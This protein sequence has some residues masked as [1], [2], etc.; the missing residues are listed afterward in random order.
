MTLSLK[1]KM[2]FSMSLLAA[3]CTV[4]AEVV[5][6]AAL[7]QS[8]D[9]SIKQQLQATATNLVS[10]GISNYSDLE[11]VENLDFFIE[12]TLQLEKINQV[13]Q[14]FNRKGKLMFGSPPAANPEFAK[15]FSPQDSPFFSMRELGGKKYKIL[16]TPYKS[17]TGKEYFLQ[18]AMAYPQF[19]EIVRGTLHWAFLLFLVLLMMAF[20]ISHFLVK[21][22]LSP[23]RSIAVYLN[24][25]DP[26]TTRQWAPLIIPKS[27]EYLGDIV[28]GINQLT[29][30]IKSS[31]Y[32]MSRI[33]RYLAHELRNPL[34]ILSGEAQT[35]LKDPK[36][37]PT[38]YQKVLES[39]LEEIDRMDNVVSTIS[40]IFRGS[41]AVYRP[42]PSD[43]G[44]WL[45][46]QL[47]AWNKTIKT[48]LSQHEKGIM[49]MI[50][51]DL[52]YRL[53][54]NLVRNIKKHAP[55]SV[56][57]M[58]LEREGE[59]VRIIV[60]DEGPGMPPQLIE[61]LNNRD[62]SH[63]PIGIGLSLCLEIAV[64]CNFKLKF[65]NNTPSGLRVSV[66]L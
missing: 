9:I 47:P 54:D 59:K 55:A 36:A 14:V 3:L 27:D 2:T 11:A 31:L 52:L 58:R 8:T 46:E 62:L 18:I 64:I 42:V 38:D 45:E 29:L 65:S 4:L 49:A 51:P 35:V 13:I 30:R 63:A 7:V 53:L 16:T 25:L 21:R 33:S 56:C 10:L 26:S 24:E 37:T 22:L 1:S 43:L 41:Q 23:V 28:A 60:E 48:V 15:I 19:A 32:G 50:E 61:A 34:T 57:L 44:V 66:G 12:Q 40:K 5:T 6:V 20:W 39:S 17:E